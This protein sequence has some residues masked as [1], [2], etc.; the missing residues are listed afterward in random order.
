MK[1]KNIYL[2]IGQFALATS[3]LLNHFI[4]GSDTISFT[5]GILTGLTL[6]FNVA[7]IMSLRK[8]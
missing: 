8:D 6:V 2:A 3:I 7:F 4:K 5:I 1:N